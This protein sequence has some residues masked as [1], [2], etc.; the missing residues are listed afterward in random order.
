MNK[1][2]KI[3]ENEQKSSK[4]IKMNKIIKNDQFGQKIEKKLE[5]K[6]KSNL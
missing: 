2:I 4:L 5:E 6:K 1:K 3:G